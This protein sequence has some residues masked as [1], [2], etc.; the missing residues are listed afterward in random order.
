LEHGGRILREDE[1]IRLVG[2]PIV[3]IDFARANDGLQL[4]LETHQ[5]IEVAI[6]PGGELQDELIH[7]SP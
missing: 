1:D 6:T 4:V 2:T 3:P 5:R 7:E